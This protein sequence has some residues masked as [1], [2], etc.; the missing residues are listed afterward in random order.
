MRS[1]GRQR[2]KESETQRSAKPQE[3]FKAYPLAA[4]F[5]WEQDLEPSVVLRDMRS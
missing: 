4:G 1:R 3:E 2:E 5:S